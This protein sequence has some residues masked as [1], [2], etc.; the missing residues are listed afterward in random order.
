MFRNVLNIPLGVR[1]I[2]WATAIRFIGWGFA[3]SFIPIFLLSFAHNY[4]DTG[5]LRSVFDVVFLLSLPIVS[6]FANRM[7]GKKIILSGLV[8]YP[9]IAVSYYLA[10]AY[11]LV[12]FV[13]IARVLNGVSFSL[14]SV[15]RRTYMRRLSHKN[16]GELF[17]YYDTVSSFWWIVAGAVGLILIKFIEIHVLLLAIIPTVLVAF[18]IV[19]FVPA[20]RISG[21]V[22]KRGIFKEVIRDYGEMFS[23]IRNWSLEQKYLGSLYALMGV[24]FVVVTFFI[25]LVTFVNGQ[26]YTTLYLLTALSIAPYLFGVPIGYLADRAHVSSLRTV[27]FVAV[28]LLA[29][30]PFASSI[31]FT[32]CIVFL[33][34]VCVYFVMLALERLA[35]E[36]EKKLK[37]GSLSGAFLSIYQLTQV[38]APVCI[39]FFIDSV[40]IS[41][42]IITVA[43]IGF[44]AILPMFVLNIKFFEK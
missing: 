40:S 25:P 39:G 12:V 34:S 23:F 36:H 31:Y 28:L 15:G 37:M 3:E 30:L 26:S 7:S 24:I 42:A 27:S 6:H 18:V 14:D 41:F 4:T 13:L 29:S 21:P 33:I 20:E 32:Y 1:L 35:T 16:V 10:G 17:G 2:S 44:V 9:F 43:V 19:S 22:V 5:L 38:L 11:G 8:I